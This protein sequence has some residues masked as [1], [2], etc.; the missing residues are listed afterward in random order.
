[1]KPLRSVLFLPASNPRAIEKARALACDAVVLDLEDAVGP[2]EKDEARRAAVAAVRDGG[3]SAAT[4]AVRTNDLA[5]PWGE[6]DLRALVE[7]A[8]AAVVAPKVSSAEVVRAYEGA[9]CAAPEPVRLWAMIET[10]AALLNLREIAGAGGRLQ[11]LIFGG[12]D[13]SKDLRRAVSADRT[14]LHPGL[15]WTVAAARANGLTPIDAV[16]NATEHAAGFEAECREGRDFGFDGKSLIHPSQ[17]EA[18]NRVFS[19]SEAEIAWARAVVDAFADPANAGK[20]VLRVGGAMA[21]RLHLEQAERVL[22]LAGR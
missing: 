8:P 21:E 15:A 13:M 9:L 17:I 20:G 2:D 7:I 18:C 5:G 16:F 14:A 22:A 1:M 3:F 4:V 19:P 6:A 10:T 11:A 12:N